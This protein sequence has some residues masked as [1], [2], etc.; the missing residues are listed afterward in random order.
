MKF[1][2]LAL[3]ASTLAAAPFA[4][5]AQDAGTTIYGNDDQP[6]GTVETNDGTTVTVDTGTYKAPL[7]AN[8][9]GQREIGYSVNATKDQINGMMAAQKAE[10]EQKLA[11]ALVDGASVMSAD[12]QA[13][14][15]IIAIDDA[16][17]QIIVER[18]DG[19]FSLKREQ[20]ALNP[21][22]ALMALYTLE[23]I[24]SFTTEVPE[25][26]E[27]RTASGTLIRSADG[28]SQAS[29]PGAGSTGASD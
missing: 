19:I 18:E 17:D 28:T 29:A 16:A 13:A 15:T 26:A 14:G 8:L 12:N 2:K 27:I 5:H 9:I 20:F 25:G 22:G 10:A 6:I 3:L 7:P 4:A 11:A 23:Q 1:A 21:E 24:A